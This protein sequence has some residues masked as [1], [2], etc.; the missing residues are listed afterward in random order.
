MREHGTGP[1]RKDGGHPLPL[2]P[3]APV[4]KGKHTAM[5]DHQIPSEASRSHQ[6]VGDTSINELP[7]RDDSMLPLGKLA[8]DLG[9]HRFPTRLRA[10]LLKRINFPC[11]SHGF[12]MR[13]ARLA[14]SRL[15]ARSLLGRGARVAR[16]L[17]N[18]A[19][20]RARCG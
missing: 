3:D 10:G 5:D 1:A 4:A 13:L 19:H 17:S 15:H 14:V 12:L 8:D 11:Y 20:Q 6:L 9:S 2:S 7:G 16:A 18:F